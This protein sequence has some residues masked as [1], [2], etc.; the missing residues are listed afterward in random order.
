MWLNVQWF[1]ADDVLVREDGAYGPLAVDLDGEPALVDTILDLHDPNTTIY[2][3]H[4]G[5]TQAW[6]LRLLDYGLSPGLP[7]GFDRVTGAIEMTLGELAASI[8]RYRSEVRPD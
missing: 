8:D 1:D 2:D 6:A 3:A 5:M 7:L 4:Y